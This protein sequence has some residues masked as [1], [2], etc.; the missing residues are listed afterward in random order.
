MAPQALEKAQIPPGNGAARDAWDPQDAA[1]IRG[2]A[3]ASGLQKPAEES[4]PLDA[5]LTDR[6]KTA[7]QQLEKA[8]SAPGNGMG[9]R[10]ARPL[11]AT[12]V[13]PAVADPGAFRR[14][15]VRATLNGVA[16]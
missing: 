6:L 9:A 14:L 11:G 2:E 8:E 15:N 12:L 1:P 10:W 5:P 4:L 16:A 3:S 7:P 13:S